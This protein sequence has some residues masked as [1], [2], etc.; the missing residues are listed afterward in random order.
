MYKKKCIKAVHIKKLCNKLTRKD[1][2]LKDVQGIL[3]KSLITSL[4]LIT[5]ERD[6]N[7]ATFKHL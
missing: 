1:K 7:V 6:N 3:G 4:P 2:V 5:L